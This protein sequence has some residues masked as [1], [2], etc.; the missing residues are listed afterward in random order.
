[1]KKLACIAVAAAFL[2]VAAPADEAQ[3]QVSFGPQVVLWDFSDL[4]VGARVNF[5]LGDAFGIED[6]FFEELTGSFNA[7]YLLDDFDDATTLLF[8]VNAMVPFE[9]DADIT[10]F[11][12]A[13]INHY[14]I[15]VDGPS[16][17]S[18]S[19]LNLLGGLNLSL[20]DIPAFT[21]LQY[22]TTGAGFLSLSFGVMFGG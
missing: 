4:G 13:G 7:N 6:G 10:P 20:G 2:L 1:M 12:G 14:R 18:R 22:S 3:A 17:S 8:N 21:E 9:I 11:A 16:S 5:G 19:G 15:S